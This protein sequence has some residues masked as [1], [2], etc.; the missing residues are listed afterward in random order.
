MHAAHRHTEAF[1]FACSPEEKNRVG[2]SFG[3]VSEK[4]EFA[5]AA[6]LS[7]ESSPAPLPAQRPDPHLTRGRYRQHQDNAPRSTGKR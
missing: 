7:L 5:P 6:L 3:F 1:L 4:D 2:S